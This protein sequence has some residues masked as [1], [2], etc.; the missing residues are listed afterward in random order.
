MYFYHHKV[1]SVRFVKPKNG[2]TRKVFF[3]VTS[4][5]KNRY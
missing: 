2:A 3:D 1:Y 5:C 4:I